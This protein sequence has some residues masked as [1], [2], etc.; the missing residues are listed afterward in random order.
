MGKQKA[1][2]CKCIKC[3]EPAVAFYPMIDIDIKSYPYCRECLEKAKL[4][5]MIALYDVGLN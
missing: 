5:M 1:S 3:K 2:D 4:E